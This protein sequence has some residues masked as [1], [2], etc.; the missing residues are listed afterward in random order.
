MHNQCVFMDFTLYFAGV[1]LMSKESVF[2]NL[3]FLAK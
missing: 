3:K 1:D 2:L